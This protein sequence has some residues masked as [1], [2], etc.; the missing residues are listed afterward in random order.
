MIKT[1]TG[2]PIAGQSEAMAGLLPPA[3]LNSY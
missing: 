3:V 2:G 1:V